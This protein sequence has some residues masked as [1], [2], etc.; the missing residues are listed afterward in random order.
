[1]LLSTFTLKGALT[2][3]GA[4]DRA[5][6]YL[7]GIIYQPIKL[8]ILASGAAVDVD[9][10]GFMIEEKWREIGYHNVQTH[11]NLDL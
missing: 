1:M 5:V 11:Q 2:L 3:T 9:S 6:N 10:N 7:P 4:T 8:E